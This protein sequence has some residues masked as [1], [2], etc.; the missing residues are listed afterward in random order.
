MKMKKLLVAAL[1]VIFILGT[2]STGFAAVSNVPEDVEGTKYE[3]AVV[4]LIALGI[5]N[6]F[7]DGTFRPAEPVTRAQM[8]KIIDAALGVAN[9]AQYVDDTAFVDTA[10]HW[11]KGYIKVAA[12]MGIVNGVGNGKFDPEGKV[13]YA[14]A[15]TMIV[16]ALGYEPKAKAIG[17]YPG[18]Y[19]AVAAEEGIDDGVNVVSSLSA[20]RGDIAKMIDNALDVPMMYQKTWGQYPEFVAD[21]EDKTLLKEKLDVK[22]FKADVT[23]I[24]KVDDTLD[25]DEIT[26]ANAEDSDNDG[27]YKVIVDFDAEA[28]FGKK[29]KVWVNDDDEIFFIAVDTDEDDIFVDSVNADAT[30]N[31]V[32]LKVE[33][34]EFDWIASPTIYVNFVGG[35]AKTGV[36]EGMYGIFIRNDDDEITFANL[37][38]FEG[39]GVVKKVDGD[40]I[41]YVDLTDATSDDEELDLDDYDNVYVLNA[42]FSKADLDDI[43]ENSVI[44][45]WDREF[46]GDDELFIVVVNNKV[47]GELERI[48]DD[49]IKVDGKSYDRASDAIA[50]LDKGDDFV[51]W[52]AIADIED[53][54]D[55]EVTVLL[56]MNGEAVYIVGDVDVTSDTIYGIVTYAELD[57]DGK[58]TVFTKDGEEVTYTAEDR[59]DVSGLEQDNEGNA[60]NY[61]GI[62]SDDSLVYPIVSFKLN[63]D[64]EIDKGET[65][66]KVIVTGDD[67]TD[68]AKEYTISKDDGDKF[69]E[70][71]GGRFYINEDTIIMKALDSD[72]LDPSIIDYDDLVDMQFDNKVAVVFGDVDKD[73]DFIV[74]L[75]D[76]F[77]GTK[78]EVYFGIVTDSPWKVGDDYKAEIDVFTEGKDEYTVAEKVYFDKATLVAFD[79]NNKNEAEWI[80]F[81]DLDDD[82]A[83]V[84]SQA[85]GL[86]DASIVSGTVTDV[87][88]K[89]ISIE[90]TVY[91]FDSDA[92]VYNIKLDDSTWKLG[93]KIS[94]SKIDVDDE[95]SVLIDEDGIV[96]AATVKYAEDLQ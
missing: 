1:A 94:I 7:E 53:L 46:D 75:E 56:D 69:V 40:V 16:R 45:Y 83:D 58:V 48:K 38:D 61:F 67:V 21:D 95:I 80:V 59:S 55:E 89:Y 85:G 11:A 31:V 71:T 14:Q 51:D 12:D 20:T 6:G 47:E 92:V 90:G 26:L 30:E 70:F 82:P 44:Y 10:N 22:E 17:G 25:A 35:K 39:K 64:G 66:T 84:T 24:A 5:I 41:E 78:D 79:F 76:D 50:S 33:D 2:V 18:G 87:D 77:E 62:A 43:D 42:D 36:Y 15:I 29:V 72:E 28:I 23:A 9:A 86:T 93:D 3:D 27:D 88:G 60:I 37:F 57:K 49:E 91:K 34:E 8:A 19:L 52:S 65:F 73:A 54:M 63:S 68:N 81:D 13:T 96:K 32:E 74:F 4:R